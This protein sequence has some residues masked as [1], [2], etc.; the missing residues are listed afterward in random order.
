MCVRGFDGKGTLWSS[1]LGAVI[2]GEEPPP[3]G[4]EK[5]TKRKPLGRGLSSY[6]LFKAALDFLG[7]CIHIPS[8]VICAD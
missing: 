5:G 6:Q 8:F 3:S 4:N 7:E 1:I 2:S